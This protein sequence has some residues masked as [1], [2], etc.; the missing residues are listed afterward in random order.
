MTFLKLGLL[1]TED[2]EG[3]LFLET[4]QNE[5]SARNTLL[6]LARP[7]LYLQM[8]I[9]IVS[10]FINILRS[11]VFE[12]VL[13]PRELNF[14]SL[15]NLQLGAASYSV[16]L[17]FAIMASVLLLQLEI[18]LLILLR[19]KIVSAL[20]GFYKHTIAHWTQQ[21][22]TQVGIGESAHIISR[23]AAIFSDGLSAQVTLISNLIVILLSSILLYHWVG[24]AGIIG[25][26]A[27]AIMLPVFQRLQR[28][29]ETLYQD[30]S[31][32]SEKRTSLLV[33][34][35]KKHDA[36]IFGR[37]SNILIEKMSSIFNLELNAI[38]GQVR[39]SI[40][41]EISYLIVPL[42][43]TSLV[44]LTM[45]ISGRS[46][47]P[48]TMISIVFVLRTLTEPLGF[49][50][51]YFQ[52]LGQAKIAG[53]RIEKW[54][55]QLQSISN[56]NDHIPI[57]NWGRR[58]IIAD[59]SGAS[60]QGA[61]EALAKS[62]ANS[63]CS[64]N[65]CAL[66]TPESQLFQGTVRE[67]LALG[68]NI[69]ELK[70]LNA[71]QICG[72]VHECSLSDFVDFEGNNFSG[73]QRQRLLLARIV[74]QSPD[75]IFL[76]EPFSALDLP[77]ARVLAVN[78]FGQ[79]WN[80]K[81][82][83]ISTA[84]P[85]WYLEHIQIH[86]IVQFDSN[87]GWKKTVEVSQ[88]TFSH[89]LN[90]QTHAIQ[91]NKELLPARFDKSIEAKNT[92]LSALS[93]FQRLL[94]LG[95]KSTLMFWIV[96]I[97]FAI[98]GF[99]IALLSYFS[100]VFSLLEM[101]NR[102]DL[103][104]A[105][106]SLLGATVLIS[107]GFVVRAFILQ[108]TLKSAG[109]AV[110][111]FAHR[112]LF[113][114]FDSFAKIN[115]S[116]WQERLTVDLPR[117]LLSG[118]IQFEKVTLAVSFCI[119]AFIYAM[120]SNP[121][122]SIYFFALFS[123]LIGTALIYSHYQTRAQ[124]LTSEKREI[125][126]SKLLELS[127]TYFELSLLQKSDYIAGIYSNTYENWAR[128]YLNQTIQTRI[129]S[130]CVATMTSGLIS[131][132]LFDSIQNNQLAGVGMSLTLLL[133]VWSPLASFAMSFAEF[134][135]DL[136]SLK[137]IVEVLPE[138]SEDLLDVPKLTS[139]QHNCTLQNNRLMF[140]K[141]R[142]LKP[143]LDRI[144]FPQLK[145][146]SSV[147]DFV[148]IQGASGCGKSQLLRFICESVS[149]QESDSGFLV[150]GVPQDPFVCDLDD[151][152]F[153]SL[154]IKELLAIHSLCL[155]G[156][157]E[158]EVRNIVQHELLRANYNLAQLG[159]DIRQYLLIL[160]TAAS[161]AKVKLFDEPFSQMSPLLEMA[162][163]AVLNAFSAT[164]INIIVSHKNSY[165]PFA[166]WNMKSENSNGNQMSVR[167]FSTKS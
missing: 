69:S 9:A 20:T 48:A 85:D 35:L 153:L 145:F 125:F 139:E 82:V 135:T 27:V 118:F 36:V 163:W 67:N 151:V 60:H 6:K 59:A 161:D 81:I 37:K 126:T 47:L 58:V 104:M 144:N 143:E 127:S 119:V 32:A 140:E 108:K 162:S 80:E 101:K 56:K 142:N 141:N 116:S 75:C 50:P 73:G 157:V 17:I 53:Q 24:F 131:I 136:V 39:W 130:I 79:E 74:A 49:V 106:V 51:H 44:F 54:C 62:F 147:G 124:K 138:T 103:I 96:A 137:R 70:L 42:V 150:V 98:S 115:R 88:N 149:K 156:D 154:S 5:N 78:L 158:V 61:L 132:I 105:S 133:S 14:E 25:V 2:R 123:V 97:V 102:H 93:A 95:S 83:Y 10:S 63:N 117:I 43:A 122:K 26:I 86:N 159:P 23:D 92:E 40:L 52:D 111:E 99:S 4:H 100:E 72:M 148:M 87:N 90:A 11:Y 28:I 129:F 31:E 21:K 30:S 109:R 165:F 155:S 8:T 110:F 166:H 107:V 113:F 55:S 114:G 91:T 64:K 77:Q 160:E 120:T 89:N 38:S 112:N 3:K 15:K 46:I 76:H 71:L 22:C 84:T 146:N 66:Y 121:T 94:F 18:H 128:A 65:I 33:D 152:S 57:Q 41:T 13:N 7:A 45:S 68:S 1:D 12:L 29:A 134:R 16:A 34:A 167:V 164:A 19:M